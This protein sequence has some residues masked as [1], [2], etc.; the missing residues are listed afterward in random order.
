M[1]QK[2]KKKEK[3]K[4]RAAGYLDSRRTEIAKW[5][6]SPKDNEKGQNQVHFS[7]RGNISQQKECDN[8]K[9]NNDQNIYASMASMCNND[10]FP[11]RNLGDSS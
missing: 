11:S 7:E 3:E 2:Y 4:I 1:F 8:S 10:E 6:N 9:N 5:P